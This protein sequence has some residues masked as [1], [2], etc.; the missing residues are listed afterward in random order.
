MARFRGILPI[1][2]LAGL[3]YA[4]YS[5]F[6]VRPVAPAPPAV[7]PPRAP[8]P[9]TLAG[10][11]IL[12]PSGAR[13]TA[14]G[15]PFPGLV[16]K[17]EV[18]VGATVKPGDALFRID[19]RA[20]VEHRAILAS[21]VEVAKSD[22]R[23]KEADVAARAAEIAVATAGRATAQ[24]KLDRL[25]ALPRAEELPPL[26]A[27]AAEAKSTVLDWEAQLARL[28]AAREKSSGV[29]SDDDLDRRRWQL[30][31]ARKALARAE[32]DLALAR[33]GAWAPDVAEA[34]AA[35]A[36]ADGLVAQAESNRA[37]AEADVAKAKAAVAQA[38]AALDENAA[39]IERAIVRAPAVATVL[40]V[41]VR[42]G[43]YA[44]VGRDA[45]V[46]LGDLRTLLVRV[47][48]DEE[49]V[50]MVRAGARAQA[51]ARGFPGHPFDLEF[52]RIEPWVRPKKSL[53]G[54]TNERVD[55]RVLQVIFKAGPSRLPIYAG[56][57]VDVFMEAAPRP[58]GPSSDAG[59]AAD[60]NAPTGTTP[61]MDSGR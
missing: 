15:A 50:P 34:K 42:A 17:V 39:E 49:S 28:V 48:V 8:Y 60:S 25:L 27:R 56:Q 51:V 5:V 7:P 61:A 10:T 44:T 23:T 12:E 59:P 24:A 19:D 57:Q 37:R 43:E 3:A 32:A 55:T 35:V 20:L 21:Q 36:Q 54:A 53:T 9:V 14:I 30:E 40:D 47:D 29:V 18:E 6:S 45:L 1:V 46:V 4:A 11:G 41:A 33:A 16:T 38:T 26:E 31:A 22:V 13:T 58:A 2:A 52:V